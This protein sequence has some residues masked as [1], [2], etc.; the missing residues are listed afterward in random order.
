[1]KKDNV[2][3]PDHYTQSK[4]ECIDA[5]ES[6]TENGYEYYLQGVI[7]KYI[8]RYRHKNDALEDLKK[9]E[10]YLKQLIKIKERQ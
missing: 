10:W 9:A 8:W 2:N 1:M 4:V 6:A 7:L 5:I 3:H